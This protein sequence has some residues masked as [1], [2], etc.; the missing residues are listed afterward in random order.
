MS[1]F[2]NPRY[3]FDG[4]D[5]FEDA[6][7]RQ[8]MSFIVRHEGPQA[9]ALGDW[10]AEKLNPKSVIDL[11]CGPGIYLLPYKERGASVL[12]LDACSVAGEY[13]ASS[14]FTRWDLRF[15]YIPD[16]HFDLAI[17]ME[18]FEHLHKTW[19]T[20]LCDVVCSCADTVLLTWATPG[21]G[22][23]YHVNEVS[24]EYALRLFAERH[25][26][27]PHP[28][29]GAMR[30]FLEQFRPQET[31]GEVSGWIINNSFLLTRYV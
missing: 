15:P 20:Q 3:P 29:H 17:C 19:E 6:E 28:L 10:L 5:E 16:R 21:Q 11:G 18:V 24:H 4:Y 26:Y 13:L 14:E 9:K 27:H 1:Q 22:G 25:G 30:A 23:S 8:M 2:T 12:G 7:Y 31:L